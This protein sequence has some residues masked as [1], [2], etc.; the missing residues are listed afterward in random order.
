MPNTEIKKNPIP[1]AELEALIRSFKKGTFHKIGTSRA[2][3]LPKKFAD[4]SLIKE[5]SYLVR[6]DVDYE[7]LATTIEKRA[8]GAEKGGLNGVVPET[9]GEFLFYL[10]V[11]SGKRLV[12][13]YTVPHTKGNK[14]YLLNGEEVPEAELEAMG[15]APS[16]LGIK[17]PK[18]GEEKPEQAP[19]L[20]LSLDSIVSLE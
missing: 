7:N 4:Y 13:V 16:T 14:R 1:E 17:K 2:L 8:N 19:C 9:E 5:S 20:Y 6:F 3:K 15:F 11:H 10:S 18:E 12:R